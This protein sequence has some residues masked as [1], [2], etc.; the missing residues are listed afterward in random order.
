MMKRRT[1]FPIVLALGFV[2]FHEVNAMTCNIARPYDPS[3]IELTCAIPTFSRT[4][5][6]MIFGKGDRIEIFAFPKQRPVRCEWQLARNQIHTPFLRGE[7]DLCL[8]QSVRMAVAGDKLAPGFYDLRFTIWSGATNRMEGTATFGYRVEDIPL[9][10]TRPADFGAFW[11]KARETVNAVPLNPAETFVREMNDREISEY[12]VR[13]A[14]IPEDYD[15]AGKRCDKVRLFKVQFDAPRGMRMHG[16]LA[17]PDGR[18][19]FPGL[20]VLPG[21]GCSRLPAPVEHARHGYVALMLQIHGMEV[22]QEQYAQPKEYLQYKGGKVEDEYYYGVYMACM[23][24][25]RYLAQRP[26]V[27]PAKLAA[28][29]SSQGG[30]LAIVTAGLCPEIKGVVSSLCYYG[31]WPCRDQIDALNRDKSDGLG[32]GAPPFDRTNARQNCLSYYDAMNFSPKVRAATIMCAC[33]C[34]TPSP[35]GTVYPVYRKLASGNKALYWSPC[36]NHDLMFAFERMA[37][38]WLDEQLAVKRG[39]VA[40]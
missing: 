26:D 15:P 36:T 8:D 40:L 32:A 9:A 16:W 10:D 37:W 20:L 19:P 18:G 27:D 2:S 7:G 3:K 11:K 34:D 13:N 30:L 39:G 25:V 12:N 33:L 38:R 28:A 4:R 5:E 23:Q 24:A 31:N 35:P 6:N 1:I 22:D 14:S 17:V 21:A 29:G